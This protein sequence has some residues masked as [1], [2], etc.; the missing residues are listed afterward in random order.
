[1]MDFRGSVEDTAKVILSLVIVVC[2]AS[3]ISFKIQTDLLLSFVTML[4]RSLI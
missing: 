1:M 3:A 2:R 4:Y